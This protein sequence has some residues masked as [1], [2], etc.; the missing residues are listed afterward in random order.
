MTSFA[1]LAFSFSFSIFLVF[2]FNR[3]LFFVLVFIIFSFSL[4]DSLFS[5]FPPFSFSFSLTKIT[6]CQ[7]SVYLFVGEK[8]E[9]QQGST[10]TMYEQ[11]SDFLLLNCDKRVVDDGQK[12]K[13]IITHV[14]IYTVNHKTHQNVFLIYCL[15][16]L[17]H[18]DKIWS[19]LSGVNLSH[20]NVN[21]F[22]LTGIVFLPWVSECL[23]F[24]V[25]LD[26]L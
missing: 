14:Y 22:C 15:Q 7:L 2:V 10:P 17:T 13:Q 6:L 11:L 1:L 23:G 25:P 4:T 24:N 26:T 5:R 20:R 12:L 8:S 3:F 9:G 19:I 21:V 16:N 18:C